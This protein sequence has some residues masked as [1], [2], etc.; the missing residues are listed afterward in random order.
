[1]T[2]TVLNVKD[3]KVEF[4]LDGQNR[5]AVDGISFNLEQGKILGIVG[6]SGSGKSVTSLAIMGLV[7]KPGK[8]SGGEIWFLSLI[9]I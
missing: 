2:E 5:V 9:H 6:E 7:S 3:L 4:S 1:M 8:I